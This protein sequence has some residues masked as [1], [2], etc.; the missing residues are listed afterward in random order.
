MG[1]VFKEED[2]TL[3]SDLFNR[4][5][6]DRRDDGDQFMPPDTNCTYMQ[7]IGNLIKEEEAVRTQRKTTFFSKKFDVEYPG[8]L[9]PSSWK[10]YIELERRMSSSPDKCMLHERPEYM[11]QQDVFK[12][13]IQSASPAFDKTSEDG[14]RFRVYKVGSLE[15]RTTQELN[16]KETVGAV[17][18]NNAS[19]EAP[20][21]R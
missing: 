6:S 11:A 16:G 1:S 17:F 7:R 13:I 14:M 9:Y 21:Q 5:L 10:N 15:V 18:S 4:C 2:R 19:G 12:D 20:A 8:P 3:L